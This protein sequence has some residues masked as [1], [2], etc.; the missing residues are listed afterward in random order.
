MNRPLRVTFGP[1]AFLLGAGIT[2]L[3]F[4]VRSGE[5]HFGG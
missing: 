2:V 4:G 5:R 3:L 1:G